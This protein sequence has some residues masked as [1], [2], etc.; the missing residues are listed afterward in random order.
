MR[1]F[2]RVS[3]ICSYAY[4]CYYYY[5]Y[6]Y[7]CHYYYCYYYYYYYYYYECPC[8]RGRRPPNMR[9]FGKGSVRGG[10]FMITGVQVER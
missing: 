1:F 6:H 4:C 3:L 7:Y 10:G 8:R 5:Y 9:A 2:N